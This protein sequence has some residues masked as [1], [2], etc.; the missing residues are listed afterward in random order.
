MVFGVF[1]GLHA[2]HLYFLKQAA[3]KGTKLVVVVSRDRVVQQLKHK[4]PQEGEQERLAKVRPVPGVSRAVLGDLKQ[5]SYGVIN[6]YQPDIICLGYDQRILACD[7]K[8]KMKAGFIPKLAMV[9][10]RSYQPSKNHTSI[11]CLVPKR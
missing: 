8:M 5:G 10:L 1:D 6:K 11:L 9:K 4:T 7:L 2:G 3:K